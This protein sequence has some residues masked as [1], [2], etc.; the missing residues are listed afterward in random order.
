MTELH[1]LTP[2]AILDSQ[3]TLFFT[4]ASAQAVRTRLTSARHWSDLGVYEWTPHCGMWRLTPDAAAV[5][6]TRSALSAIGYIAGIHKDSI[7]ILSEMDTV[8]QSQG[9]QMA[10]LGALTLHTSARRRVILSLEDAR[11][12]RDLR[13]ISVDLRELVFGPALTLASVHE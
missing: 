5:P 13:Q 8:F 12:P 2:G 6:G 10:L 9:L 3:N 4:T 1:G 7:F 11:I